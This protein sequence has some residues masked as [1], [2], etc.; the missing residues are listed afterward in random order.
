[1]RLVLYQ[2]D[3]APNV[4]A[5]IRIAACF[6]AGVD[7][8]GPCGFPINAREIRR[9]AM[10][11]NAL[12]Q[13]IIHD[14]WEQFHQT[15]S[16]DGGR[17]ILLTTKAEAGIWDR[18]FKAGDRIIIGQESSGAPDFVHEAADERLRIELAPNARS[19]NMAVAAGVALA[20]ARRQIG[21]D[22]A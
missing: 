4:G 20:E 18:P 5:A 14:S 12:A 3:I 9:V 8:I 1:M 10:D 16:N 11:Y 2:P 22:I 17:L 13:P 15:V 7:I 6:G 19:L 21:W